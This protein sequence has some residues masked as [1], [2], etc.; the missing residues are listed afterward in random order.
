MAALIEV[1]IDKQDDAL[2]LITLPFDEKLKSR[3]LQVPGK[4]WDPSRK[5][6]TA[7]YSIA[8]IQRLQWVFEGV[9][10]R[11]SL[12]LYEE[13]PDIRS[14]T[15]KREVQHVAE[16][17]DFPWHEP[18]RTAYR[19]QLVIRGYSPKTIRAYFGQVERF[20]RYLQQQRIPWNQDVLAAYTEYLLTN[21]HSPAD[22]NQAISAVHFLCEH[23][24]QS[25][26]TIAYVR[27][28]R[29]HKLPNVLSQQEV[30]RLLQ[31]VTNVKHRAILYLTYSSGLRVGEVVRLTLHDID[32]ERGVLHIRQGKGRRDRLTVLSAAAYSVLSDY[33]TQDRPHYWVFPG[34]RRD[35]HLT[36]R[37]VQKVF[38]AALQ[39]SGITKSVSVHSLRHSFATHLLDNGT[40]IRHIQELL[41]HQSIR[42]TERYTHVSPAHL[43]RVQ[44]PLDRLWLQD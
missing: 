7:P 20:F 39:R 28:K 2:L 12:A 6:W 19:R 31:S 32:R 42:T 18:T 34:Q 17:G 27:P 14:W 29:E 22:V 40:D 43:R 21:G 36:E 24:I 16:G 1:F 26:V 4:R 23:T 38:E 33:L 9:C 3:M 8:T 10:V 15:T 30:I 41:G 37:S 11:S 5:V 25:E 35:R 13:C 44:S